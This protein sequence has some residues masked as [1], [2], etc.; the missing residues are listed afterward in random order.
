MTSTSLETGSPLSHAMSA[1]HQEILRYL[2]PHF[3]Q[4][5]CCF[6][7]LINLLPTLPLSSLPTPPQSVPSTTPLPPYSHVLCRTFV[8]WISSLTSNS[9]TFSPTVTSTTFTIRPTR[10][11]TK[12]SGYYS[13]PPARTTMH[14]TGLSSA[15]KL[16]TVTQHICTWLGG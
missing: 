7:P 1:A 5:G 3:M 9:R 14:L 8:R 16:T 11:R 13:Q 4:V 10:T 2:A 15:L 12:S 6:V